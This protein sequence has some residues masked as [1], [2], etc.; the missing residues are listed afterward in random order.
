MWEEGSVWEWL[1]S[2]DDAWGEIVCGRCL[3]TAVCGNGGGSSRWEGGGAAAAAAAAVAA[4]ACLITP[5]PTLVVI[6]RANYNAP[7]CLLL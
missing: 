1:E 4:G 6:W 2:E 5:H 7:P 3:G